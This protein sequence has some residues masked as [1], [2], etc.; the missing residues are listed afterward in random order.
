MAQPGSKLMVLVGALAI[1]SAATAQTAVKI[2]EVLRSP[3]LYDEHDVAVFGHVRELTFGPQF[4]TFKICGNR[5][6][7]VLAWGH[8]RISDHEALSVRG[9]FHLLRLIDNQ[10]VPN[11]IEV[12][13][14]N[15]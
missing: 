3:G 15:L 6:L 4:T 7:N 2:H 8:P 12:E 11:V 14:G 1:A 9:R 13:R 10:K 5:C